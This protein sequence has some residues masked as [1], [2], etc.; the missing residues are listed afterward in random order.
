MLEETL[1]IINPTLSSGK[2]KPRE[3]KSGLTKPQSHSIALTL[4]VTLFVRAV[5][6]SPEFW[7]RILPGCQTFPRSLS[8]KFHEFLT[9]EL[10][11]QARWHP[12]QEW[13]TTI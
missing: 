2:L 12:W 1:N 7:P 6:Q 9:Q 13:G 10:I 8:W 3:V 4:K 5:S 11:H